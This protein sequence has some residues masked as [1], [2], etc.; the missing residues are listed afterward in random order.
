MGFSPDGSAER[1]VLRAIDGAQRSIRVAA[2]VFTASAVTK[3][4]VAAHKRGVE[5]RVLLDWRANFEDERRYARHAIGALVLA[6]VPVRTIDVYPI[7]HDKYMVIDDRTVQ[8][9]SYNYTVAAARH[10]AENALV[11][12][13]DPALAQAY[14]HDWEANWRLGKP[15]PH[16]F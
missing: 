6:G 9:G 13:N 1:L 2:Y 12:W 3:A 14:D 10:N 16:G 15:A 5:V 7:F 11:V 4:L 8:T